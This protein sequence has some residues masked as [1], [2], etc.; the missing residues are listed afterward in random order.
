MHKRQTHTH[1]RG[2]GA[3]R[4]I[5]TGGLAEALKVKNFEWGAFQIQNRWSNWCR[6]CRVAGGTRCRQSFGRGRVFGVWISNIKV[7]GEE[8]KL[9]QLWYRHLTDGGSYHGS[10][11][12]PKKKKKNL[13]SVK[14]YQAERHFLSLHTYHNPGVNLDVSEC[15]QSR[16]FR[17]GHKL[18]LYFRV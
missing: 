15:R 14:L 18:K 9:I 3:G 2:G 5:V 16:L 1:T 7:S 13:L 12:A 8:T 11:E 4:S 10:D 17:R 6:N